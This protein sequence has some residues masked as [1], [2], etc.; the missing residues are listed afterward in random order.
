MLSGRRQLNEVDIPQARLGAVGGNA[1]FITIA[2]KKEFRKIL[3]ERSSLDAQ[4]R[5]Q[6]FNTGLGQAN[7]DIRNQLAANA[8]IGLTQGQTY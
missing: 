3:A 6:A 7:Q 2:I 1:M 5:Q 8:A 4:M